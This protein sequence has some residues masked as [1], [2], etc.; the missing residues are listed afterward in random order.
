[1]A[2]ATAKTPKP[3]KPAMQP[4]QWAAPRPALASPPPQPPPA[5][6]AQS[7]LLKAAVI[8]LLVGAILYAAMAAF[9]LGF[10]LLFG[11]MFAA[12]GAEGE[13][14]LLG[15]VVVGIIYGIWGLF[16]AA[17]AIC[18][19]IGWRKAS[20][21]DLDGGFLWGLVGSLLPPLNIVGMLGAIFLKACPEHEAQERARRQAWASPR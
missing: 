11:V 14:G 4:P 21:G 13:P 12:L 3:A 18:G 8:L 16:A 15:G 10:A 9:I 1:M 20:R 19:F 6:P 17:G 2:T 7:G 5:A